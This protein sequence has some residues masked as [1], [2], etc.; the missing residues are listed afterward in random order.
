[1]GSIDKVI[2]IIT[3]IANALDIKQKMEI[4][5]VVDIALMVI[6][7][8]ISIIITITENRHRKTE[9]FPPLQKVKI[10]ECDKNY[11]Q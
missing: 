3:S 4:T 6:R 10:Y 8:I 2:A 1:M 9:L 5:V 7:I 11:F